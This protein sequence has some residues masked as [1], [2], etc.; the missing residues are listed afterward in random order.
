MKSRSEGFTLVEVL[1]GFTILSLF[2]ATAFQAFSMGAESSI[3][4][5]LRAKAQILAQSQLEA[6]AAGERLEPG[7][8]ERQI[9]LDGGTQTLTRH[10]QVEPGTL[11]GSLIASVRVAWDGGEV[12][13]RA[14]LVD[15]Q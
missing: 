5:E 9:V 15:P 11:A 10:M 2:I 3:R 7:E 13:M 4:A 14:L 6:L 12:D 1:V 8:S